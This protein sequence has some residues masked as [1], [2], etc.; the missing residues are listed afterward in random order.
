MAETMQGSWLS[1]QTIGERQYECAYC[2]TIVSTHLGLRFADRHGNLTPTAIYICPSCQRPTFFE[3][4]SQQPG[5]AYGGKV[6]SIA[7][8]VDAGPK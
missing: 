2:D 1:P 4:N 3:R 8:D 5:V 7:A 6:D